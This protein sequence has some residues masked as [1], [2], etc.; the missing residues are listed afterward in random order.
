MDFVGKRRW[1]FLFSAL[2]IL[3]GLVSLIIPPSLHL[4]IDFTGGS[5][6]TTKFRV[7]VSQEAVRAQLDLLG[8]PEATIQQSGGI[9]YFIRTS[10]LAGPNL[11]T[12]EPSEETQLLDA[13][14]SLGEREGTEVELVAGVIA[15]DT[16][17]SAFLIVFLAAIAI[18]LFVTYAFRSV[19]SPFRY[20]MAAII[21]LVHDLAI[22]LGIFSILGKLIDLEVNA[23]FITGM[24]FVIGYSVNDTIVVFDRIRE[25]VTRMQG[26]PLEVAVNNS[27]LESLGRSLATSL[28]LLFAILALLLL[29][30]DSIREFLIVLLIAVI[31]G[32]YSSI[33][34][35]SQFLVVWEKGE[36]RRF[37]RS[38]P[39]LPS[40]SRT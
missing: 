9:D 26:Q 16:R 2:I 11:Q 15:S 20:G 38:L 14:D 10:E 30:G 18:L 28:T 6:I 8:H 37:L 7:P 39:F 21:A 40:R 4:G 34:I 22:I 36:G 31:T 24:L 25:N 19:P 33:C 35:A 5:T 3:P 12:G 32:T 1:F 13:L 29:G 23:M 17:N 27:I